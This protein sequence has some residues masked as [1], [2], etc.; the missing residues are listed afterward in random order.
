MSLVLTERRGDHG[1]LL[2]I[3]RPRALNAINMDVLHDLDVALE[4]C[5]ADGVRFVVVTGS[6][7]K[8]FV[9]GADIA[10]MQDLSPEQA[11]AFALEGQGILSKLGSYPG[12]TIAAVNGFALGGG[13]ELAMA[14]DLILADEKARF[15]QPEVNLGV[16]PGFGGTQRLVRLVGVQ[17][18]TEL[19]LSGRM[20][21][22]PEAVSLGIALQTAPA[23][24]VVDAAF[25]LVDVL[26]TKGPAALRLAKQACYL[27]TDL[28]LAEGL[29]AEAGL[30]ARCFTDPDQKEGMS[31]FL[32]KRPAQF[33]GA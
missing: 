23:G 26:A 6:G 9:A 12:V 4:E 17:R 21:K 19:V 3:N 24:T 10:A 20:V 33:T 18:A 11:E 15:G 14:C 25:E 16:I 30:F 2:T 27:A 22:A 8:A 28:P 5:Q 32:Q 7:D 31:A 1:A 29:A 13:M